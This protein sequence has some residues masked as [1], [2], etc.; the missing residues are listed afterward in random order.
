MMR[1]RVLVASMLAVGVLT[2]AACSSG[3]PGAGH[4]GSSSVGT[5]ATT[6][7]APITT[8]STASAPNLGGTAFCGKLVAA[9][10][11]LQGMAGALSNPSSAQ[12]Y[13]N[14]LIA[15]PN[16]LKSG[17]PANVSTALDDLITVLSAE[18]SDFSNPQ[19]L[20]TAFAG[21][22]PRLQSDGTTIGT[23]IAQ[24]CAGG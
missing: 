21:I 8:A 11:K 6:T 3:T 20:A 19:A 10:Q 2:V 5:A 12:A 4:P 9:E 13:F 14:D 16:A 23:Y 24:S 18:S 1:S 15:A 17:A 22:E 7:P